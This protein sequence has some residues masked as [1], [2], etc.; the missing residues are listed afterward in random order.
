ME[1]S[2]KDQEL[3]DEIVIKLQALSKDLKRA[4]FGYWLTVGRKGQAAN[5]CGGPK[6]DVVGAVVN[7]AERNPELAH[8]LQCA[9]DESLI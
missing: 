7:L 9:L 4:G 3:H 1:F 6:D 5:Y 8:A 2:K